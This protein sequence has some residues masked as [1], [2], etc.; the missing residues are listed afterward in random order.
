VR[1]AGYGENHSALLVDSVDVTDPATGAFGLTVPIDSVRTLSVSEMPYLAQYG[2][3]TAGVVTA[4]TRQGD[5]KWHFDLND[6]LPDFRIRSG[7]RQACG[8]RH[9][10]SI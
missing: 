4:E 10:G 6:P 1:I 9:P 3:F 8:M 7:H 5:D 2:K